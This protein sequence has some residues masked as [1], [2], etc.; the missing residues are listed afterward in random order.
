MLDAHP[1]IRG[2]GED[3]IFNGNLPDFRDAYVQATLND[4]HGSR[5]ISTV[6][7]VILDH[8]NLTINKMTHL[9][10]NN[11]NQFKKLI[12]K[13]LFNYRNIGFIHLMFPHAIILHTMRDPMDTLF[14]C[15]KHR[16][17]DKGLEWT[18]DPE[19]LALQYATYLDIMYH[20]RMV[21]PGRVIDVRYEELVSNPEG[22]MKN[23]IEKLGLKWNPSILQFHSSQRI[24]Q[25]HSMQQVR[26]SIYSKSIG[27]WRQYSDEL[28]PLM[29]AFK[30]YTPDLIIKGIFFC[31]I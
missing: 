24:V 9:A 15:Y 27:S 2:M 25:T 10:G 5:G 8:A 28:R 11:H 18:L 20:F 21:L 14:S 31:I 19:A 4:Y 23:I 12:D 7:G 22:V 17:D 29:S 6:Q 30:R 1:H 16:F 13:M 26:K 3:S